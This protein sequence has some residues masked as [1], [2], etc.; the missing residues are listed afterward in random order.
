MMGK[1]GE[2]GAWNGLATEKRTMKRILWSIGAWLLCSAFGSAWGQEVKLLPPRDLGRWDVPPGNYSGI[3]PIG[4]DRYAVV[5]D[6]VAD[7]GF[8]VFQIVQDSLTGQVIEVRN[9]GFR[10]VESR[11]KGGRDA[12]GVA[13]RPED[14]TVWVGGEADQRVVAHRL[15]GTADGREL[16]VPPSLGREAIRSNYGF[17]ALAYDRETKQFW[18]VTENALKAD[19]EAAAPGVRQSVCLRLQCFDS[20]GKPCGQYAYPLDQPV[21]AIQGRQYAFGAVAIWSRENGSLWVMEREFNVSKRCLRSRTGICIY[22]VSPHRDEALPDG[23][24][25]D[26]LSSHALEKKFIAGFSTRMRLIRPRLANYE[27][28]CEGQRLADGRRTFL[29]VCDSQGRAG[30]KICHLRDWIRVMT[31]TE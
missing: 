25:S 11:L 4:E 30:N 8:F 1:N 2:A 3:V 7:D 19:G 15:D 17:E 13:F 26:S 5:S 16:S 20:F 9:E 21:S 14:A 24:P 12:E 10:G 27:G 29:L 18:T 28:L 22:E 31:F 23:L 6:K